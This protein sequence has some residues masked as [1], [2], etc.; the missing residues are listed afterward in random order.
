MKRSLMT[1]TEAAKALVA[2][3]YER[4]DAKT[5]DK[6]F[7]NRYPITDLTSDVHKLE[8]AVA[9][10]EGRDA[11]VRRQS[12]TSSVSRQYGQDALEERHESYGVLRFARV[13]SS[14]TRLFNSSIQHHHYIEM[15]L[16]RAYRNVTGTSEHIWATH[17]DPSVVEVALSAAQFAEAI[18]TMNSGDGVPCTITRVDGIRMEE[19]PSDQNTH[20]E[21]IQADFA[22]RLREVAAG[23]AKSLGQ[24]DQLLAKK[25]LTKDDKTAIRDAL[26]NGSR[27]IDDA[28]PFLLKVFGEAAEKMVAKAR[29]EIESFLDAATRR[30]GIKAIASG[31][32]KIL[33][34]DDTND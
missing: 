1:V 10:A 8:D 15:R 22:S 24:L 31:D 25:S 30:A 27:L 5:K 7:P 11:G 33:G 2:S 28:A 6:E 16:S 3:F 20:F 12:Y 34:L 26:H 21:I 32:G 13:S 19:V 4:V 9:V 14:G 23:V 18:T 17:H 29:T